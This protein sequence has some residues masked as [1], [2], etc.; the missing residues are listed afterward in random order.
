MNSA[1]DRDSIDSILKFVDRLIPFDIERQLFK[2]PC[3]DGFR[4]TLVVKT[5]DGD[6]FASEYFDYYRSK[7]LW[8]LD[9]NVRVYLLKEFALKLSNSIVANIVNQKLINFDIEE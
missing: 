2:D 6:A 1:E 9:R 8:R 3:D 7:Q 4:I 5:K